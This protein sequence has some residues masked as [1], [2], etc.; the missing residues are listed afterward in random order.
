MT[1]HKKYAITE[2]VTTYDSA[3]KPLEI[4]GQKIKYSYREFNAD[5][6]LIYE[7]LYNSAFAEIN[8]WGKLYEKTKYSYNGMQKIKGEREAGTPYEKSDD[9]R[10]RGKNIYTY[11][12]INGKLSEWLVDGKL[13]EKYIYN[14]KNELEKKFTYSPSN[15]VVYE[16]YLYSNGLKIK[17]QQF[18]ADTIYL[19]S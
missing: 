2:Y 4:I 10:E 12:Y 19:V 5:S 16:Y 17:T 8:K 18:V 1:W 14:D 13:N 6:N 9:W 7:E 15:A 3:D 11:K